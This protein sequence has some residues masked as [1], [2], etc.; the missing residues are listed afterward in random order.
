MKIMKV[1]LDIPIYAEEIARAIGTKFGGGGNPQF[2]AICTDSREVSDGDVFIALDGENTSGELFIEDA[3]AR[4]GYI[5]SSC[6][7]CGVHFCVKDTREALLN[8]AEYYKTKLRKL[9]HTV[10]I[11]GSIGKTTTKELAYHILSSKYRTHRNIGNF[12]N[13]IGVPLTILSAPADTEVLI[14]ECGMNHKGELSKLSNCIHPDIGVITNIGTAHIGNLGSRED[15]AQA[16]AEITD[17]MRGGTV[18]CDADEPLLFGIRGRVGVGVNP[19]APTELT[20][21]LRDASECGITFDFVSPLI[22]LYNVKFPHNTPNLLSPLAMAISLGVLLLVEGEQI[23]AALKA[24]PESAFRHNIVDF[25][26]FKVLCDCYNASLESIIGALA[27]LKSIP[28]KAHSALIGDVLELG[29][30]SAEIHRKIGAAIANS[31]ISRLYLF[32]NNAI[33]VAEGALEYDFPLDN[34][35]LN[36]DLSNPNV[37]ALEIIKNHT[38]GEV[39]LFKASHAVNLEKILDII[40][41][42]Y[43]NDGR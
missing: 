41:E 40:K 9:L 11:T 8:L 34:L 15:I 26:D 38:E 16:K 22:S 31:G 35:F 5:L 7:R 43:K 19:K 14:I 23:R 21:F 37:T 29:E 24:I 6:N 2:S 3:L 28:A 13:D 27:L 36:G 18:L 39:I 33:E 1:S 12:N 20:L 17:G 32:G 10:A 4:G 25:G 30:L 42:E